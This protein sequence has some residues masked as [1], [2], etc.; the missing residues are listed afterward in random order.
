MGYEMTTDDNQ[1]PAD[2]EEEHRALVTS[3]RRHMWLHFTRMGQYGDGNEIPVIERGE[4]AYVFDSRGRRYLDGLSGLFVVQVGH[5]RQELAEAASKQASQLAYFPLWSYAHP[6]SIL[7][8]ERLADLAPGDLNRVFFTT[9]GS[10]AVE[11]AWKLARQYFQA[12]GQH[13]RYKVL[14]RY[15]AYHGTTLGA[16][17]ITGVPALRA[18][19][20]P[21]VPG[22][23]K[24]PN[25]NFYRA[26]EHA[27]DLEDFGV[28]AADSI[29]Q[30]IE[31]EGPE[32]VA[33]VFLEPV[34]N[35]GGCFT[36]PPGYF[37][38][39]REIC[40]RH[41]VLLVSDEVICAFG[42]IGAM[43][44]SQRY[45]YLPDMITCAKGLTSGYSPL[46]AL[47]VRDRV[48]EPFLDPT[49][50]FTHGLTFAGHPVSSAVALANLDIIE[51]EDLIG[52]VREN[53]G[54]F[55]SRLEGL[56]DLPIVGDV[57][58]AGYFV[59]IELVKDKSTKATFTHEEAERLLRGY[60]SPAL[61][62]AGLICRADD[63][64]DPVIQL[65][66]P[67]IC[68]P[69]HFDVIEQV[70]RSVLSEAS[71]RI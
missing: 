68:G 67:L 39:V 26:T 55:R 52:H 34:Q 48:M 23:V 65:S 62:E 37:Q 64:G 1:T 44:G 51:R 13:G 46:G 57:R 41:Q 22:A 24:V 50:S 61:F 56:R 14:S 17:S 49:R 25:T 10:E 18:P 2:R 45:D 71:S 42:R 8:A 36:P 12:I 6:S 30:A 15:L 16:L 20:E 7:L 9:G 35:S 63:R 19:F 66:P 60:L 47:I 21:L 11:S 5:G 32:S 31:L 40:D 4:G 28:W 38:R 29:E 43:F 59:A 54:A 69:E 33:A 3:A 53:E 70:L 58:G 27:D